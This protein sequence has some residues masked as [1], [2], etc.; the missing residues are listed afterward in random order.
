MLILY[1]LRAGTEKNVSEL[2]GRTR[3]A[4]HEES[5]NLSVRSSGGMIRRARS[6]NGATHRVHATSGAPPRTRSAYGAIL[7]VLFLVFPPRTA[8]SQNQVVAREN[9]SILSDPWLVARADSGLKALY[10]LD[11]RRADSLFTLVSDRYPG[12][13]IGSFLAGL[14]IWWRI[15]P[16]L[17]AGEKV[18]DERFF[19]AMDS[20]VARSD[21]LLKKDRDNFDAMFFKGAALGFRGR[22]YSNRRRWLDA[23]KDGRETLDYIFRIAESD[24]ANADFQ[25][26]KG[27]YDYFAAVIPKTY[28]IVRPM[29]F[30]FPKADRER[31]LR[32]LEFTARSGRYIQTEAVYFLLQIHLFYERDAA[33]ALGEVRWLRT[34]YPQNAWFHALEGRVYVQK[35]DH[36]RAADVFRDVWDRWA[37]GQ[38]GYTDALAAQSAYYLGRFE[39]NNGNFSQA[40]GYFDRSDSLSGPDA[41]N[42]TALNTALRRGMIYDLLGERARAVT[43]YDRALRMEDRGDVHKR[44]KA[45]KKNPYG[46]KK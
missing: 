17:E 3:P 39:A 34:Q 35:A 19:M 12:H 11:D 38:R 7:I 44:A 37:R 45:Y 23:A 24:S 43:A 5:T 13:P 1:G 22:L 18:E 30:F 46:S 32:E 10:N 8:R 6:T 2:P 14:Q 20:V 26:G 25:F 27:V 41:D 15:L 21:K 36:A 31:G 16:N 42:A 33:K 28:P 29:M 9:P 40:L 4:A